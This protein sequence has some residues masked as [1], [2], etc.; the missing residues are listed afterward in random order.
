MGL[1][2]PIRSLKSGTLVEKAQRQQW[3]S[4]K[5]HAWIDSKVVL[6][7]NMHLT[8]PPAAGSRCAA[9]EDQIQIFISALGRGHWLDINP[10]R[11]SDDAKL[12]SDASRPQCSWRVAA[13]LP[14]H[15]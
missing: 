14:T 5:S 15:T 12:P 7:L 9:L 3:R 13:H 2:R 10:V 6:L 11:L 8:P 1:C 4:A